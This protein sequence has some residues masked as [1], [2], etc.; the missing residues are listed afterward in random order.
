MT[1]KKKD[2]AAKAAKNAK[3][4]QKTEKKEKKKTSKS[5]DF[6]EDDNQNLE[7]ME[8]MRKEW[9]EARKGSE[10]LVEEP[11]RRRADATLTPRPNGSHLRCILTGENQYLYKTYSLSRREPISPQDEGR[12]S[13][14]N[15][16]WLVANFRL[17]T[18]P[19]FTTTAISGTSTSQH[20]HGIESTPKSDPVHARVT[21]EYKPNL[22][23]FGNILAEAGLDEEE[24]KRSA[25]AGPQSNTAQS[26]NR[27]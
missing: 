21:A 11:P 16:S 5:K 14:G 25:A 13:A 18:K 7:E 22:P 8:S 1:K 6:E 23:E 17:Y 20:I 3:A 12:A 9:E 4:V 2:N 15:S 10:E 27:R 24:M 19:R 26:R